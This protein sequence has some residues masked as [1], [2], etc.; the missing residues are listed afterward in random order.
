MLAQA[1]TGPSHPCE[2]V[3]TAP[4]K[5]ALPEGTEGK[6]WSGLFPSRAFRATRSSLPCAVGW[7]TCHFLVCRHLLLGGHVGGPHS[8]CSLLLDKCVQG[9]S[10]HWP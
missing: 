10:Q 5:P 9:N 8:L 2:V 1:T 7:L 3:L 4:C 6:G